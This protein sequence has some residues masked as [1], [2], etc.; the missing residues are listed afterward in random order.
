MALKHFGQF[1][2]E[3]T[4]YAMG[5]SSGGAF[6][7][8][9]LTSRIVKGALV[10]VMSL[11]EDR[12]RHI[13]NVHVV[14]RDRFK[15]YLAPMPRDKSTLRH[16]IQNYHDLYNVHEYVKLDDTSCVALPVTTEY[17]MQRVVGMTFHLGE[18]LISKLKVAGH[19]DDETNML[20]KDPTRSNWR[21]VITITT[22]LSSSGEERTNTTHWLGIY[23]LRPGISP[24]AKALHRAWAFHEYCSEVV[25]PALQFFEEDDDPSHH[26]IE[27]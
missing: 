21:D 14:R 16:V 17:L 9:L 27:L 6:A 2:D 11:S 24:L 8:Q 26:R 7:A 15:L 22:P 19:I 20:L 1:D 5:A 23:D 18:R 13:E 3:Y 25:V 4:V 10:M 12:I